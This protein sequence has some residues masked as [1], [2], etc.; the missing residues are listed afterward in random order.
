MYIYDLKKYRNN[1][2]ALLG[3]LIISIPFSFYS[4]IENQS[5]SFFTL[6][7]VIL[8][9]SLVNIGKEKKQMNIV[10]L[11][12]PMLT[13][14]ILFVFL[15]FQSSYHTYLTDGFIKIMI[16]LLPL[17]AVIRTINLSD[18]H[19][20]YLI[21]L[22]IGTAFISGLMVLIQFTASTFYGITDWGLQ[23]EFAARKGFAGLFYDFS[24][25]SVFMAGTSVILT[26]SFF[27]RKPIFKY[28][29]DILLSFCF[30]CFSALTSARSGLVAFFITLCL[31]FLIE[32]KAGA[33]IMSLLLAIPVGTIILYVFS[34]TE[35]TFHLNDPGRLDH[36]SNAIN[37]FLENPIWG[38]KILGYYELTGQT[39][40]HNFIIDFLVEYGA[41]I[42]IVLLML[43]FMFVM[44]G[45]KRCPILAYLL[46]AFSIGGLFHASFINTHY[47]VVP[48]YLIS[49]MSPLPN[50]R[51]RLQS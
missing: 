33:L 8:I 25:M 7:Q 13:V 50:S 38:S 2:F 31:F 23:I 6:I 29:I 22:F 5:I 19:I 1:G 26:I 47:I 42:T 51:Q 24:I 43:F 27:N 3:L 35:R 9:L 40:V 44:K 45:F 14:I 18:K 37:F 15:Y 10:L 39:R 16:F 28:R 20:L 32:R 36:Y 11:L 46:L 48:L 49:S 4:V 34:L 17:Y 21:Q 30:L 12:L 41:I